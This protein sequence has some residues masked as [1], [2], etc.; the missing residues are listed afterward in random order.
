VYNAGTGVWTLTLADGQPLLPGDALQV[1]YTVTVDLDAVKGSVLTNSA[2]IA[3]Y[4]SKES[5]DT[6]ER[7]VYDEVGPETQDIIVGMSVSGFVYEQLIPNGIK[8]ST[9]DWSDG[10]DVYVNIV[11][12]DPINYGSFTAPSNEVLRSVL[13][14]SGAGDYN[15]DALPSGNYR[16]V[17]T[18]G[19]L[20]TNPVAPSGWVFDTPDDGEI[21]P[22]VLSDT[23]I[24]DQNFGLYRPRTLSG[25]VYRDTAPYGTK[26]GDDWT[27]GID[28]VVNLVDRFDDANTVLESI[29]I[30]AGSSGNFAFEDLAP[31][32][33]RLIVAPA[34]A[35]TAT[36]AQAPADWVFVNPANGTREDIEL[37]TVDIVDQDFG[38]TPGRTVSGFVFNDTIPNGTLDVG[39]EDW[40][41]GPQVFVNL[42]RASTN[43]VVDTFTVNPGPGS[44]EFTNVGPGEYRIIV[45]NA[46]AEPNAIAP[47]TWLFRN[48]ANGTLN[49]NVAEDDFT[50]ENFAL[51]RGRTVS[52]VV[53]RDTG[54]D[55][56]VP[57]DGFRNGAEPGIGN[58]TVRLFDAANNLLD[59]T[60]TDGGGNFRLRIPAETEDG[61]ILI[62]EESNPPNHISTGATV[63]SAGGTYDRTTDRITFA[64]PDDDVIGLAF[65]DVPANALLTDG[66]Q[67]ILPGASAYYR[68]TF[69]AGS[70]GTVVFEIDSTNTPE[71]PWTHRLFRDLGCDGAI[72]GGD[73]IIEGVPIVVQAGEEICLVM[74]ANA[75]QGA[76]FGAVSTTMVMASFT[77][78]NAD[79]ALPVDVST[80]QDITTVGPSA[81]A[82]LQLEKSVDKTTASPGE[83][84]TY[85]ITYTNAGA[86]M[87]YDLFIDDR[88]PAFTVF[89]SAEAGSFPDAL[90]SVD[91]TAPDPGQTGTIRWTFT[92]E[93]AP[94]SSGEVSF[95]VRVE[96]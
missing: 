85:T 13:V 64:F 42:V 58:V 9:E 30:P 82:G 59:I 92:G 28:V 41:T 71:I 31:G 79:P 66:A 45:T 53:F 40:T 63:G 73:P 44:Y 10:V 17:I 46:P 52:G 48:P 75:P 80:R 24:V 54:V 8:D 11:T 20:N 37:T 47:A 65:G 23:D 50:E 86:E 72:A 87:L 1:D 16:I 25:Q 60:Q 56:G 83:V 3:A 91:I 19:P 14:G 12:I 57:N 21:T 90:T 2:I 39:L 55:G 74:Q 49:I 81:S 89:E 4:A 18:D 7:R 77:Y 70:G 34:G 96:Q 15:L 62:V 67:T 29:A 69:I 61:D 22:V 32:L 5:A 78:T 68:H 43:V 93:L 36:T 94:G 51:F 33:Y 26:G 35:T 95:E 88:T 27:T 6:D 84:I 76:P 38:L